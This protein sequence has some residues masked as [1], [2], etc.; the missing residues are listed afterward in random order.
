L[1][2]DCGA[3]SNSH[4]C[5]DHALK[6]G[7]AASSPLHSASTYRDHN[8]LQLLRQ[9]GPIRAYILLLLFLGC[10]VASARHH[11]HADSEGGPPGQFDYYLLSLSWSPT[12]CLTHQDDRAQCAGKGYGFVLHGLWPQYD[13]GGYPRDCTDS[14]L[15]A[16]AEALGET[17]YP[18]PKLVQHEWAQHGT[19][20]GVDAM[21]YFRTAD[22]ATAVVQVP[23]VFEAPRT[24][25]LMTSEQ[26]VSAFRAANPS[27]PEQG[28]TLICSRGQLSEVR[29]CLNRAL[30]VRSCGRGVR[31]NCPPV[32]VQVRS[33]R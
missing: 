17:L 28:L 19:C 14:P 12:Y 20:S 23:E 4:V 13:S 21:T 2:N 10:S 1:Q 16:D 26:I 6:R 30:A 9:L 3:K 7:A 11:R 15:T 8:K 18:S 25:L 22:R 31:S 33:R 5:A 27:L 32:P 24:M 29:I